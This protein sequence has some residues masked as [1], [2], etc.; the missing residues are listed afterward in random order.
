LIPRSDREAS[1]HGDGV[2]KESVSYRRVAHLNGL[3]LMRATFVGQSLSRHM[4]ENFAVG[5]V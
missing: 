5:V 4:H 2:L 3:E 1:G